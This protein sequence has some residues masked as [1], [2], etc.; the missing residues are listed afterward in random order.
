M[1]N[2]R[3]TFVCRRQK[4][5][6]DG[7]PSRFTAGYGDRREVTFPIAHHDGCYVADPDTLDR[8]EGEGR[9]LFRYLDNPNGSARDIAGICNAAGN[10]LGLMPHPE[11]AVDLAHGG[12]DGV[13]L[14]RSVMEAA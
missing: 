3:L 8:L 9:V 5:A 12:D 4:L 1:R 7:A 13:A 2:A 6:I 11:R 10:V 14:I